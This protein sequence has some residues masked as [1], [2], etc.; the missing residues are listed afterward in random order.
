MTDQGQV[1]EIKQL[2]QQFREAELLLLLLL[3]WLSSV[4]F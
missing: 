3:L 4:Q 1:A 2:I